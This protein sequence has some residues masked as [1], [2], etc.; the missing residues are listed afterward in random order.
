MPVVVIKLKGSPDVLRLPGKA[1]K[2]VQLE[3][4]IIRNGD[5]VEGEFPLDDVGQWFNDPND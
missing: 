3:K 2:N 4:L 1:E 5:S